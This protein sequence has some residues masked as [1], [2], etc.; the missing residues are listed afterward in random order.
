MLPVS[1]TVS[2]CATLGIAKRVSTTSMRRQFGLRPTDELWEGHMFR[3]LSA[4]ACAI[5][6]LLVSNV[7]ARACNPQSAALDMFYKQ[8]LNLLRPARDY[9]KPGGMVFV[10]PDG[11]AEYE[12]PKDDVAPEPG[13]LIDFRAAILEETADSTAGFGLALG[14]AKAVVPLSLG[15]GLNSERHVSLGGI[16]TTGKRLQSTALDTLLR[17]PNTLRAALDELPINRVFIVQEIYQATSVDLSASDKKSF[18]V[19]LNDGSAVAQCS[20]KEAPKAEAAKPASNAPGQKQK[21]NEKKSG[22]APTQ[23][24]GKENKPEDAVKKGAETPSDTSTTPAAGVPKTTGAAAFCMDGSYT[25]KLRAT[26]P[27]PFAV[28]LAEVTK[29]GK[30]AVKRLRGRTVKITL[31]DRDEEIAADTLTFSTVSELRKRDNKSK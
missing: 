10:T 11:V 7:S 16:E 13:N 9:V 18:S 2:R 21:E 26:Q 12:D 6:V 25:L 1:C 14:L 8:G 31:G 15:A 4:S 30:S 20:S 23:P 29:D 24:S 17:Q 3:R 19:T 5:T 27:I 22:D 28:R